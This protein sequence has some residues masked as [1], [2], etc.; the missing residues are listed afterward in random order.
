MVGFPADAQSISDHKQIAETTGAAN[1]I[2][3]GYVVPL[4]G[5]AQGAGEQMVEG[6]KLYLEQIHNKMAGRPVEVLIRN[7]GTNPA[8]AVQYTHEL[9]EKEHVPILSG[10]YMTNALYAMA[11]VAESLQ[12]PFVVVSSGAADVTQRKSSKWIVRTCYA[13]TQLGF[14][15]ADYAIK[16]LHYKKVA[17]IGADYAFGWE[18]VGSFQQNFEQQGGKV[19][20]KLW[21]PLGLADFTATLQSLK[22]D[23]DAVF[24]VA[25][26]QQVQPILKGYHDLGLKM[27]VMGSTNTFDSFVFPQLGDYIIGDRCTTLYTTALN[28]PANKAFVD[29]FRKK[30]NTDTSFVA[31][32]GYTAMMIIHKAVEAVKG[33]V[34]DKEAF[35][36]ALKRVELKDAPRGPVKFDDYGSSIENVYFTKVD[37]VNGTLQNIVVDKYPNVTQF[38]NYEPSDYLKQ[39]PFTREYPPCKNCAQ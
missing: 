39:P 30:Y 24:I 20:Q 27:P 14:A 31:E 21:A 15:S 22:K 34:E 28:T 10:V 9:I 6:M 2:R 29:A 5:A 12:T 26:G 4:S 18:V 13:S 35:L 11:P 32:H 19:V 3:I 36:T 17:T 37:K 33:N 25:V 1:P 23:V 8:S 38:W 16:K 7:D